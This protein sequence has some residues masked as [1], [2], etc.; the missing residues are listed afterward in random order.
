MSRIHKI[1]WLLAPYWLSRQG[2][3]GWMLLVI[4]FVLT[5]LS[6][7]SSVYFAEWNNTFYDALVSK[8]YD[9]IMNEVFRF[10]YLLSA[11]AIIA[12]NRTYFL[13]WLKLDWREW[14][15]K[16]YTAQWLKDNHFY[17][18]NQDKSIDNVDQRIS[19][20]IDSFIHGTTTLFFN[21]AD[22]MMTIGSF[23]VVL[24]NVSGVLELNIF[25]QDYAIR[26]YLVYCAFIYALLG[27]FFAKLL[28][29]RFKFLNWQKEKVEADYRRRIM[30][31]TEHDEAIAFDNI[32][33]KEQTLLRQYFEG[34][35]A[36]TRETM[37][38]QRRFN[39]YTLFYGQGMFLPPLFLVLP[40]YLSG[41]V[42][43]G[44]Y[45]QIRIAF[46][47]VVGSLSWFTNSY[48]AI[49]S[50]FATIDRVADVKTA[51]HQ[52]I[53]SGVN[54]SHSDDSLSFNKVEITKPS[55]ESLIFIENWSIRSGEKWL[56]K[57]ASGRGKTSLIKAVVG[58]WPFSS[59]D[60]SKPEK[61]MVISQRDFL[62]N[63]SLRETI[64]YTCRQQHS[65]REIIAA[66]KTVKLEKYADKLDQIENWQ[67]VLSGG[68]RQRIK[69]AKCFLEKP[70]WLIL[71]EAFSAID[72]ATAELIFTELNAALPDSA[73]LCVAHN[74]WVNRH[75]THQFQLSG[76]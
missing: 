55:G 22:A 59:G 58:L 20:D 38:V 33:H 23:S 69:L 19:S 11:M 36:N 24:W 21:C 29:D 41:V 64:T 45:M 74:Q 43:L 8:Q 12:V 75:F 25:G 57:A 66:L 42:D 40:Q 53:S 5:S 17:H 67:K 30:T 7:Y 26:G 28:G 62:P 46:S 61:M 34:I 54:F 15:T 2:R 49:M 76:R 47:Q 10:I 44:G 9:L 39:L 52:P 35:I 73:I 37:T 56:L 72:Q 31:I 70:S 63:L 3:R 4:T 18:V 32:A 51:I 13:T 71:D 6:T 68:E 50:W 48:D 16:T 60:I 65:D 1:Y 14:M 27:F